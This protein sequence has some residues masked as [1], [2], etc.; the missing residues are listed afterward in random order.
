VSVLDVPVRSVHSIAEIGERHAL[1]VA[2]VSLA[3]ALYFGLL[4]DPAIV[5]DLEAMAEGVEAEA[6]ALVA[7]G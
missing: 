3:G 2:V 6:A 4:A 7:A 1:R 5:D